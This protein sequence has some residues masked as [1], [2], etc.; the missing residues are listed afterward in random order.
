MCHTEDDRFNRKN[1]K[2]ILWRIIDI[3]KHVNIVSNRR[4]IHT[5]RYQMNWIEIT[6]IKLQTHKMFKIDVGSYLSYYRI[7]SH[8]RFKKHFFTSVI[9][10]KSYEYLN[11]LRLF[12][13]KVNI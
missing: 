2:Y 13:Y 11:V 10:C 5:F 3:S 4:K 7:A 9:I 1:E 6:M 12:I 8:S